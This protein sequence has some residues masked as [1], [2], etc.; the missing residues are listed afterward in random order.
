MPAAFTV[1][2]KNLKEVLAELRKVEPDLR[3]E[4]P[5][6]MRSEIKP[7][8]QKLGQAIPKQAPLSGMSRKSGVT[9]RW[10]WAS[11][12]NRVVTPLGKRTKKPGFYPVV[13]MR[14]RSGSKAAGYEIVE[15]ARYG[16]S[17]QGQAF[18]RNLNSRYPVRGGL[19]RFVIPEARESGGE[20]FRVAQQ[21][22]EKYVAKVNRRLR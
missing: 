9:G 2:A 20:V 15:K 13:S 7:Y 17:P 19:G 16:S 21:I 6:E 11:V 3:K 14:F 8:A 10:L 5:K 4:L 22:I 12:G 18:I 1:D